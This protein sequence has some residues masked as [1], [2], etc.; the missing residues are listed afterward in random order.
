MANITVRTS[1]TATDPSSTSAKGS[2]LSHTE[3]DSNFILL[4][5]EKLENTGSPDLTGNLQV[6]GSGGSAV[7]AVRFFDNDDSNYVELKSPATVASNETFILPSA[8]GSAGQ[9][10]KTDGSGNLSFA[11]VSGGGSGDITRVNITA[12]T[13]LSGTQDT[14][15]GDHTQT[16][17]IDSTVTTLTGTQTLTNK[18]LTAPILTGSS[19]SAG[20]I[21]FNEDTDNGTNAVTL[22]GPAATADVTV[23]LPAAATTLVGT[24]TTDTLTNKTLTT[25]VI[26]SISN[27]GTLTLPT[28]TDTLVGRATTDTLTNKTLTSPSIAGGTITSQIDVNDDTKINFGADSDAFVR[29]RN[30]NSQLEANIFGNLM[31]NISDSGA[32]GKG[33]VRIRADNKVELEAGKDRDST[34]DLLLTSFDDFQFR[35]NG[36]ASTDTTVGATTNGTTSVTLSRSLDQGEQNALSDEALFFFDGDADSSSSSGGLRD[37]G[38]YI[39]VT[40]VS[41]AGSSTVITLEDAIS[42]LSNATHSAKPFLQV[43]N[44]STAVVVDGTRGR[45]EDKF[46]ILQNRMGFE[47][48]NGCVL[49]WESVE[50][51]DGSEYKGT[52]TGQSDDGTERPVKYEMFTEANKNNLTLTHQTTTNDSNTTKD[53][54]EIRGRSTTTST[55][56]S[57]TAPDLI[58]FNVDIDAEKPIVLHNQS[59]DPSGITDASHI[60]A[61]DES[62]SSEVFVR[63]ES[64]TVTR[65]SSHNEDGEWEYYSYHKPTGKR[66]KI[67]MEEMIRDIEKLTGKNYIRNV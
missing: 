5:N 60:Y 62:G 20:A 57:K 64:G 35:K 30:S 45:L 44:K 18:S 67:N 55:V 32:S 38:R 65:I 37:M 8:D 46:L 24:D 40:G 34:G 17:A 61:K 9:F 22:I 10:L 36:F 14:T 11:T 59:G 2:A 53:I 1:T 12:G 15:T 29:W 25:P 42:N 49:A 52:G 48:P 27:T 63:D 50:F 23:T 7:G 19:S 3:L 58:R 13:G 56:A 28:S 43:S 54:F 51:H 33:N 16:L 41:G 6:K 21:L 66:I 47:G 26:A 31:V 4:N 39:Q